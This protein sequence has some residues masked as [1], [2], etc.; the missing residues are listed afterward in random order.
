MKR[1]GN[2]VNKTIT[3]KKYDEKALS[4]YKFSITYHEF[5]L[6]ELFLTIKS[7]CSKWHGTCKK[8]SLSSVSGQKQGLGRGGNHKIWM[9]VGHKNLVWEGRSLNY[10][11]GLKYKAMAING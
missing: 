6:L 3:A 4:I 1:I 8:M 10:F 9:A 2:V 7:S 11:K 5:W